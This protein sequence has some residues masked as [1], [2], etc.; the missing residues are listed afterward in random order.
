MA[1]ETFPTQK[2]TNV[3][4]FNKN[5]LLVIF[6]VDLYPTYKKED[7]IKILTNNYNGKVWYDQLPIFFF[8]FKI[9][10]YIYLDILVRTWYISTFCLVIYLYLM[11]VY[12]NYFL[13]NNWLALDVT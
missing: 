1:I 7:K 2:W 4:S 10:K 5:G 6:D 3:H 8:F 11:Y 13:P 12:S 9:A